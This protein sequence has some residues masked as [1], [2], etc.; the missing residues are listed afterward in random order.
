MQLM[1]QGARLAY[2]VRKIEGDVERERAVYD[3]EKGLTRKMVREPGGYM[4]YFPR[5]HVLRLSEALLKQYR[6]D[7]PANIIN[8]EGLYDPNS[9]LGKL[10]MAEDEG[11]RTMAFKQL[12][13]MCIRMATVKTGPIV[14]PEQLAEAERPRARQTKVA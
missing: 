13:E 3:K 12:E 10:L 2:A 7:R 1:M 6:L 5:G 4:V 9:P 14:M 8:M 11:G